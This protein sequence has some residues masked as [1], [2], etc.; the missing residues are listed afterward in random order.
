MNLLSKIKLL[1]CE[2]IFSKYDYFIIWFVL[3]GYLNLVKLLEDCV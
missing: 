2:N 1:S 3:L